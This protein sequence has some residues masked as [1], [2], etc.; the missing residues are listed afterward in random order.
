MTML[1]AVEEVMS[2]LPETPRRIAALTEGVASD[3]LQA[4][5][6]F[7]GWSANEVLAHLRACAD[8]WGDCMRTILTEDTPTL[9]AINPRRWIRDTDYPRQD[10]RRSL[11]A[12]AK[13]RAGLLAV[14]EPL[15]PE[16]W[17]RM[18]NVKVWGSVYERTVL[19]Y[20]QWLARH[21]RSHYRPLQRIA[22]SLRA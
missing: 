11:R 10:F 7:G 21:E 14:V 4:P 5:P 17:A 12:F 22:E 3:R 13:Q 9:T 6:P 18:A 8:V 19:F 1:A 2:I 15:S 20:A 16:E